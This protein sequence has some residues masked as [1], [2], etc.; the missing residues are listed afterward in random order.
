MEVEEK[1][2]LAERLQSHAVA[3]SIAPEGVKKNDGSES[4][5]P[6][7]MVNS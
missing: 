2:Y 1:S 7:R 5:D 6:G 3:W 4:S